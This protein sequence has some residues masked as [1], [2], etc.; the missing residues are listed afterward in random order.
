[1]GDRLVKKC[2]VLSN[3]MHVAL[4]QLVCPL[5]FSSHIKQTTINNKYRVSSLLLSFPTLKD[6]SVFGMEKYQ[7]AKY[8]EQI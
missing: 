4:E 7:I 8:T 5:F 6:K 1:M 2:A 3:Q